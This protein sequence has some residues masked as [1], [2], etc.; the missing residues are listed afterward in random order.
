M[1]KYT[2]DD[3]IIAVSKIFPNESKDCILDLLNSYGI[4]DYEYEKER[5]HLS[6]L[7][8]S[9]GDTN[10]LLQYIQAAKGDYRDV[11]SLAE[12]DKD[13]KEIFNPYQELGI[14]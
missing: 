10:K 2:K 4:K 1:K 14:N 12:Y 6:I 3:V 8:L 9:M 5:V 11:L 13:G 7:K